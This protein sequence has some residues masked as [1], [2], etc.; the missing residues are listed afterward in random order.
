MH[1][2]TLPI[3]TLTDAFT[4]NESNTQPEEI[5][6]GSID[7]H[8]E[9]NPLDHITLMMGDS[10][11]DSDEV[12]QA[13]SPS[14]IEYLQSQEAQEQM[15]GVYQRIQELFGVVDGNNEVL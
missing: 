1:L 12:R 9:Q 13:D 2:D 14:L 11:S 3:A 4:A 6:L 10:D 15:G 5:S 8:G 7:V